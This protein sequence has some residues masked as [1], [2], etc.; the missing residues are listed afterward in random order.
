MVIIIIFSFF[1]HF[2]MFLLAAVNIYL[3]DEA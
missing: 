2:A 3:L 1:L